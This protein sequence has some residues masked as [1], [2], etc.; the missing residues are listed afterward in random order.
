MKRGRGAR[1]GDWLL[2]SRGVVCIQTSYL[3]KTQ[4]NYWSL[5]SLWHRLP[6]LPQLCNDLKRNRKKRA[7]LQTK[8]CIKLTSCHF[9]ASSF[10][11]LLKTHCEWWSNVRPKPL[12]LVGGLKTLKVFLNIC[13]H[14]HFYLTV[15][16]FLVHASSLE[17]SWYTLPRCSW[18]LEPFN[19]KKLK[20]S[21]L[22]QRRFPGDGRAG[23]CQYLP[24]APWSQSSLPVGLTASLCS[25]QYWRLNTNEY[26]SRLLTERFC[27][28]FS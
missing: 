8:G 20:T 12:N 5:F 19:H 6:P 18:G 4:Y 14:R 16:R 25:H 24:W 3:K 15:L 22:K 7:Q 17:P 13:K 11:L 27:C 9:I 26:W 10:V 28:Q 1:H 23:C 2:G 21:T